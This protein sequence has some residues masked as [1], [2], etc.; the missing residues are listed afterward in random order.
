[1]KETTLRAIIRWIHI[2]CAIPII[3]YIY[4]PFANLPDYATPTRFV[5]FPVMLL[6]GVWM[7]KGHLVRRMMS[8][9]AG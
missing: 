1:M 6:S 4:S 9:K 3:G 2:I 8:E 5:F 7:W